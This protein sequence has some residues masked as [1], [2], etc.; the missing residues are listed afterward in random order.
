LHPLAESR[1]CY[2]PQRRALPNS[3]LAPSPRRG[4]LGRGDFGASLQ[5]INRPTYHV[6]NRANIFVQLLIP[7]AN[8]T[9][10]ARAQPVRTPL[11]MLNSGRHQML[12]AIKLDNEFVRKANKINHVRT[13]SRLTAKLPN[14]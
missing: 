13:D 6:Y 10:A 2:Q 3:R 5:L 7:E 8:N 14:T 4:G 12:R 11:V 9:E 1:H